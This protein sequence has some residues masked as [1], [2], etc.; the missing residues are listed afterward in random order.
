MTS[1]VPDITEVIPTPLGSSAVVVGGSGDDR[2][3]VFFNGLGFNLRPSKEN[4]YQRGTEQSRKQQLDVSESPGEQ[5][6]SSWWTR[7]QDTWDMGAGIKWYEPGTEPE[8]YKRF[9]NSQGVDVWTPGELKLLP[10]MIAS[11][12]LASDGVYYAEPMYV[13]GD[14]GEFMAA[15]GAESTGARARWYPRDGVGGTVNLVDVTTTHIGRPV[16]SGSTAWFGITNGIAEWTPTASDPIA[17]KWTCTGNPRVWLVK[18]RLIVALG[19]ALYEL[20]PGA[21]SGTLASAAT[22]LYTH[23]DAGWVWTGV[24][25]TGAAIIAAGRAGGVSSIFRFTLEQDETNQPVLSGAAPV[26]QLPRDEHIYCM[27]V[28]LGTYLVLGTNRGIR[29]GVTNEQ[30]A[31]QYG[32]L[33]VPLDEPPADILFDDRFAYVAVSRALPDGTSGLV[34]IDLSA[35]IG[36]TGKYPWAW[37]LSSSVT[38]TPLA[39]SRSFFTDGEPQWHI[40]LEGYLAGSL[41]AGDDIHYFVGSGWVDTGRVRF[42]T[43]EPKAFRLARMVCDTNGGRVRLDTTTPSGTEVRVIEFD[44]TFVTSEQVAIQIPGKV[45]THQYL[46]FTIT[47]TGADAGEF[48]EGGPVVSTATPIVNGLAVKAVPAAARVRL[49]QYPLSLF[50]RED[51]RHGVPLVP[52][53][54]SAYQRLRE[55]ERLEET[56]APVVVKDKRTGETYTGQIDTVDFTDPYPSDG[57]E[58]GFGGVATVVVRRLG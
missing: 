5:S 4:P 34:R 38:A 49:F 19:P 28:Y 46:S 35:P 21:A 57:H 23:P 24:A 18:A 58:S 45:Q 40:S 29:V 55:L 43:S 32:P 52:G 26:A 56:G 2:F 50:D 3:D 51:N 53:S 42:G 14:P 41:F 33:T 13:D 15:I 25:E 7:S 30:G 48:T 39:V 36:D 11:E 54:G 20:A 9:A 16:I 1:T 37:D 17:A 44:D 10:A 27:G 31:V 22:L 6:L 12:F 47:L 8:T